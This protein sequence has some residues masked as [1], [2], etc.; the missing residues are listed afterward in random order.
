MSVGW[1][2]PRKGRPGIG[3][4]RP[5]GGEEVYLYSFFN[6][7]ARWG[8]GGQRHAPAALLRGKRHGAHCTGG[9]VGL[10]TGL[11]K[12]GK[13]R[14]P[15]GN[16]SPDYPARSKS[17]YRLRYRG[18]LCNLLFSSTLSLTSALDGGGWSTPRSGRFTPGKETRCPLYRRLGGPQGRSGQV[19]KISPPH[20]ESIPGLPSP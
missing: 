15:T 12:C 9:W 16:R 13:S 3:P 20:R 18:P 11:D 5:R 4:R 17:T 7:G 6:F 19:R 14:P 1:S 2:T 8:V 10:R